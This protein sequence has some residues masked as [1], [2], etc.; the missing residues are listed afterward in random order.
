LTDEIAKAELSGTC[1]LKAVQ[2][3]ESS[4]HK[5]RE[6]TE[7]SDQA[8]FNQKGYTTDGFNEVDADVD[9]TIENPLTEIAGPENGREHLPEDLKSKR[10]KSSDH[11]SEQSDT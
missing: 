10:Q 2:E 8:F 1:E 11:K 9:R 7:K 5:N 6:D 4:S 3:S